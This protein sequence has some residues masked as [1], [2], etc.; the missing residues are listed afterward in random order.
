MREGRCDGRGASTPDVVIKRQFPSASVLWVRR[1]FNSGGGGLDARPSQERRSAHSREPAGG[2]ADPGRTGWS[3]CPLA[4][5]ST[6]PEP[7]NRHWLCYKRHEG[8]RLGCS[9][10]CFVFYSHIEQRSQTAAAWSVAGLLRA[11][12]AGSL[13]ACPGG[14]CGIRGVWAITTPVARPLH[15]AC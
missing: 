1:M 7:A 10:R 4:P 2:R 11:A 9:R 15:P 12:A 3:I 14:D 13:K 5:S 6:Q 8:K